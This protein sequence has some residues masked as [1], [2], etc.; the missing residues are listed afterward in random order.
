MNLNSNQFLKIRP[1]NDH[2][3]EFEIFENVAGKRPK[4]WHI[5]F[6]N[7]QIQNRHSIDSKIRLFEE[8]FETLRLGLKTL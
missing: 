2:F 8:K 5:V 3:V 4:R 7:S 6:A 1:I